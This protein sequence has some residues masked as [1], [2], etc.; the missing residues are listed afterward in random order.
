MQV[1]YPTQREGGENTLLEKRT[2]K[3]AYSQKGYKVPYSNL[4]QG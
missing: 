3:L 2:T 1:R 4:D